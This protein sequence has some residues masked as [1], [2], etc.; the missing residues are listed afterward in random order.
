MSEQSGEEDEL[1]L[2]AE[3]TPDGFVVREKEN[4]DAYVQAEETVD[5]VAWR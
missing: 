3:F 2:L 5:L 4:G 1:D